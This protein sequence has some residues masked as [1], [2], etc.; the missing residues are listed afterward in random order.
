MCKGL[1]SRER[2]VSLPP[3][4][5]GFRP[6][7][8][9]RGEPVRPAPVG[10]GLRGNDVGSPSAPRLWV[11]AFAG[12]TW[13][14]RPPRACGFRPSRERRGEPVRPAPV[15]SGLRGNDVGSPS[16]P[17]LWVPA[18][19]GTTWG[20]RPPR[21]CGFRPSRERRGEPVRP[22]PV[23]SGLRRNDV[24]SPA[25]TTPVGSGLRRNDG[26]GGHLTGRTDQGAIMEVSD[27]GSGSSR[28]WRHFSR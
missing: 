27:F 2:Q 25:R 14:A 3:R 18:F 7:R 28:L 26:W 17:R 11:P 22:A 5:C 1:L 12:T 8:E 23:G 13:G 21:A 24:G 15:G 10:S 9:R 20:A 19:A 16:A 6:S 4:A